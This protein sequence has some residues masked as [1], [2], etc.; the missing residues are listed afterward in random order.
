MCE[1]IFRKKINMKECELVYRPNRARKA[2]SI[3][4]LLVI[5]F[6]LCNG[7]CAVVQPRIMN[8][9]L[10]TTC[11]AVCFALELLRICSAC[12]LPDFSILF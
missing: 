2:I 10:F 12:L 9:C 6:Y 5:S 1:S 3:Y 4:L 7:A 8:A 11:I